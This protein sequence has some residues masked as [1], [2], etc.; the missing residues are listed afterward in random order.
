MRAPIL[1]LILTLAIVTTLACDDSTSTPEAEDTDVLRDEVVASLDALAAEL[2]AERP[3]DGAAYMDRLQAYLDDHPAFYGSA[4]ALLDR[5][6]TITASPYVHRTDSG[7]ATLDLAVPSYNI[8]AQAWVT[9]PLAA[10]AGV[11]TEP[12]FD[13]GGGEIWMITRSVPVRD[14]E[15]VFA[16]VTT[17]LPV[18]APAQ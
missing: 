10:D 17:D 8:E 7:Y 3:A 1:I 18:D 6:G 16:I 9:A 4:A 11:W 12:Y 5:D 13:E 2:A 14:V 15:G